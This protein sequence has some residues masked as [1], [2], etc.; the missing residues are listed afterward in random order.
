MTTRTINERARDVELV[1]DAITSAVK[2]ALPAM[3]RREVEMQLSR[4]GKQDEARQAPAGNSPG[5]PRKSGDVPH[6]WPG[7]LPRPAKP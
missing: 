4:A 6:P 1:A 7:T 5:L 2:I 3:V